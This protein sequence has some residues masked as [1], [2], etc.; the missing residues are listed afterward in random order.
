MNTEWALHIARTIE[1]HF[2]YRLETK[3]PLSRCELILEDEFKLILRN[4]VDGKL[5]Y[6]LLNCLLAGFC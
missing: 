1:C 4:R 3:R 6:L 5:I 2:G